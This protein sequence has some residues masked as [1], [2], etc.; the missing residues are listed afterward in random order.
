MAVD[1]KPSGATFEAGTPKELFDSP[2]VNLTHS[3]VG[4][5]AGPY[6]AYAVSADGQ[7]FLI[8]HPP[9]SNTA[10]PTMP[11]AVVVNWAAGL[12]K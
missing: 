2:Y 9:S 1:V 12:K 8:P 7:R 3:A 10:N 5:G 11:I 6:Q 4:P